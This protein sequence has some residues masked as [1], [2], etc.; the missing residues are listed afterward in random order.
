MSLDATR[1]RFFHCH[2]LKHVSILK[3]RQH[4][5]SG[6]QSGLPLLTGARAD[7]AGTLDGRRRR[8]AECRRSRGKQCMPP[9]PGEDA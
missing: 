8:R 1:L 3:P 6:S 5:L 7:T 9:P 2:V 4:V